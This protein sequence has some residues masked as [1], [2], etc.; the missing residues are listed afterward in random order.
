MIQL[1]DTND[2]EERLGR[3]ELD[4]GFNNICILASKDSLSSLVDC[5]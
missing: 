3:S 1:L 5:A 4:F 2:D